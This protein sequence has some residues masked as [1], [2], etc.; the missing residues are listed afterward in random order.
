MRDLNCIM[1]YVGRCK[2]RNN[3]IAELRNSGITNFTGYNT[4]PQG[5]GHVRVSYT[6][7][8]TL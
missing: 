7:N 4:R 5:E 6:V 2:T 1:P 3:G 8:T